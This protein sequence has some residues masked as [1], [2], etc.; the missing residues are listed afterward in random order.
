MLLQVSTESELGVAGSWDNGIHLKM[1]GTPY[2]LAV[3][4]C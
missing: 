1:S 2:L 3:F 4:L